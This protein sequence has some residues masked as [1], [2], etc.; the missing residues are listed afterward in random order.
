MS[1]VP[2]SGIARCRLLSFCPGRRCSSEGID[3]FG[4]SMA[5]SFSIDRYRGLHPRLLM[6]SLGGAGN[7]QTLSSLTGFNL[8]EAGSLRHRRKF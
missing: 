1:G 8:G 5:E 4:L 3:A 6:V 2:R 7:G